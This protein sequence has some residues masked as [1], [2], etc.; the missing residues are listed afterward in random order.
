MSMFGGDKRKNGRGTAQVE[1]LIGARMKIRGDLE[2]S[3]GLYIEGTVH[4]NIRAV[5]GEDATLTIADN[6][7]VEGEIEAPVVVVC[8]QLRGNVYAGERIEL[9][10]SARVEGDI[11]YAVVEMAAGA[12]I[13]GRLV[14]GQKAP[15]QLTGPES[16]AKTRP[17][18]DTATEARTARSESEQAAAS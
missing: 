8:G 5:S 12:M 11:H 9:G 6:G 14:H 1:T 7:L 17:G 18:D 16:K 4:G 2:F 3:G 15:R 10:D 13:T